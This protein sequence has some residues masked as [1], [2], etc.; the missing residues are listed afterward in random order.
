[1]GQGV[2]YFSSKLK[3]KNV[4]GGEHIHYWTAI[5]VGDQTVYASID[6][7]TVLMEKKDSLAKVDEHHKLQNDHLNAVTFAEDLGR[8]AFGKKD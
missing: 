7:E 2:Y 5:V 3:T 8:I 4:F 1:M 6:S